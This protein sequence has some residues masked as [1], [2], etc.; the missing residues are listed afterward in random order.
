VAAG[1]ARQGSGLSAGEVTAASGAPA[2]RRGHAWG[3]PPHHGPPTYLANLGDVF[4]AVYR[5]VLPDLPI[6]P[7]IMPGMD[8]YSVLCTRAADGIRK[9]G[10]FG[11]PEQW[12]FDGSGATPG[13]SGWTSS[14]PS[15]ATASSP[16][17]AGSAAGRDAGFATSIDVESTARSANQHGNHLALGTNAMTPHRR[18]ADQ[19]CRLPAVAARRA[20]LRGNPAAAPVPQPAPAPLGPMLDAPQADLGQVEHL[21][22]DPRRAQ[23]PPRLG[24][25]LGR[26]SQATQPAGR[27][28]TDARPGRRRS[29]PTRPSQTQG[30]RSRAAAPAPA[31]VGPRRRGCRRTR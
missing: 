2:P 8:G 27:G 29:P 16:G 28:C 10:R 23:R 30:W 25:A 4:S 21:P 24:S 7:Q 1:V 17:Q 20:G 31:S 12:R 18:V 11:D 22:C 13:P 15:A 6:Y 5:R 9:V 14:R 19:P 26:V 3:H